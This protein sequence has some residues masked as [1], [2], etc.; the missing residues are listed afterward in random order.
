[1]LTFEPI[2]VE[3]D[4]VN[5]ILNKEYLIRAGHLSSFAHME[6]NSLNSLIRPSLV[7]LSSKIFD[8][9]DT[10]IIS[11]AAISQFVYMASTI[12]TNVREDKGGSK[13]SNTLEIDP[14]DGSQFPVL[15]GDYL[16][17]KSFKLLCSTRVVEFLKHFSKV[18]CAIHEG[19]ILKQKTNGC[20]FIDPAVQKEIAYKETG[21]LF[22]MA[23][24]LPAK[25]AG[26]S[27][28]EENRITCFGRELGTAYGLMENNMDYEIIEPH[29]EKAQDILLQ[30]PK[31]EYQG[32]LQKLLIRLRRDA[33]A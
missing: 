26:A 8:Y 27:I 5:L 24:W 14:R 2:R 23:S 30:L 22:E 21:S 19:S 7:I 17:G 13:G 31:N 28:I 33:A 29:F 4:Q 6:Y 11:L 9:I 1:M 3:L 15:V 12:H 25:L 16:Y 20:G 32:V 10:Q 18:I